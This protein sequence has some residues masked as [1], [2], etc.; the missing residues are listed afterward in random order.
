[1]EG[2]E[3]ETG[4]GKYLLKYTTEYSKD[5]N[6]STY[7]NISV[8]FNGE[9]IIDQDIHEIANLIRA[10]YDT[11]FSE[12]MASVMLPLEDMSL[13]IETNQIKIKVV[14]RNMN[15]SNDGTADNYFELDGIYFSEK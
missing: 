6:V 12:S 1:M 11:K 10:K 13:E 15:L 8:E 2:V 14:M 3:I 4:K 7:P 9:T 5:T